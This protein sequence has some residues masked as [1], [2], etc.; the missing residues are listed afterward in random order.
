[1]KRHLADFIRNKK[2]FNPRIVLKSLYYNFF[3]ESTIYANNRLLELLEKKQV[4]FTFFITGEIAKIHPGEIKKI[5]GKKHEIASH[6]FNHISHNNLSQQECFEDL[7]KSIQTFREIGIRVNGFRAPY[8]EANHDCYS[9][10][11]KLGLKYSSSTVAYAP[12]IYPV[13]SKTKKQFKV[14][15]IME[16]PITAPCEWQLIVAQNITNPKTL[17][18]KW[19]QMTKDNDVLLLH[20]VRIGNKKF[21]KALE[22]FIDS[23]AKKTSFITM[24]EKADGKKG[25]CLTGDIGTFKK[26]D[27]FKLLFGKN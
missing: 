26:T 3:S 13:F 10:A 14:D 11:K 23:K 2:G 27:Y 6:G 9:N 22:L 8:M 20:P 15:G 17:A 16:I 19:I 1:M 5:F 21:I 12:S 25:I 4:P 7:E 18:E 24:K